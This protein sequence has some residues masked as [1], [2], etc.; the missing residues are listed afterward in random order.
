MK[1][2]SVAYVILKVIMWIMIVLF[3]GDFVMQT[4][5]YSFYKGDRKLEQ[6]TFQP[7]KIQVDEGLTGYGYALEQNSDNVITQLSS[8]ILFSSVN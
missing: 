4:I 8:V 5:S 2:M 6:V 3:I 1:K 7:E